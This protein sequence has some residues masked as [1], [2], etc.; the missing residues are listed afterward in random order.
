MADGVGDVLDGDAVVAHSGHGRVPAFMGV[1][2]AWCSAAWRRSWAFRAMRMR[3]GRVKERF[4][5][6]P[7]VLGYRFRLKRTHILALLAGVGQRLRPP[8]YRRLDR[9]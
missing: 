3:L 6:L 4:L 2:V 7:P 8:R 5:G 9:G 1:P